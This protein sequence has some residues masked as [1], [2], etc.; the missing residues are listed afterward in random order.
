LLPHEQY[1]GGRLGEARE[2]DGGEVLP[3]GARGDVNVKLDLGVVADGVLTEHVV[4]VDVLGGV[5]EDGLHEAG[6][7]V[8]GQGAEDLADGVLRGALDGLGLCGEAGALRAGLGADGEDFLSRAP[9]CGAAKRR[10][11]SAMRRAMHGRG[12]EQ[13][14]GYLRGKDETRRAGAPSG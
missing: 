3:Q 14:I 11:A 4:G 6:I 12:T 1:D 9:A 5:L 13:R 8:W 10:I 7:D 2:H